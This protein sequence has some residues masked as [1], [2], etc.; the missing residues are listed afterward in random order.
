MVLFYIFYHFHQ[1]KN[2]KSNHPSAAQSF[3][4]QNQTKKLNFSVQIQSSSD[5]MIRVLLN[6]E[7][8]PF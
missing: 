4:K 3:K 2:N 8:F 5:R 7:V 6:N 1:E